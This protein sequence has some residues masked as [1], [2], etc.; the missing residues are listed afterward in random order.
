MVTIQ[1]LGYTLPVRCNFNIERHLDIQKILVL[2]EV[3]SH[4]TL[5]V[6]K[7]EVQLPNCF[8][9]IALRIVHAMSIK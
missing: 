4:F 1:N 3:M 7:L 9:L 2:S 6:S 5:G 8:L